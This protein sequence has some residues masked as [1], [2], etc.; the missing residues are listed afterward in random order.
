M[1]D[2]IAAARALGISLEDAAAQ[3]FRGIRFAEDGVS[4]EADFP[5]GHGYGVRRTALHELMVERAAA[6]GVRLIWDGRVSGIDGRCREVDGRQVRARW[7]VGADGGNSPTRRWAGL[8][9]CERDSRR[10]AFRRHYRVAP[11]SEFME[12]HWS[13]GCQI[14]ITPVSP[15][16]ICVVL[17]SRDPH[18]RLEDALMRFPEI[19]RRLEAGAAVQPGARRRLGFPAFAIG[20]QRPRGAGGRRLR[21]GGCHHRRGHLPA[22]PAGGAFGRGARSGRPGAVPGRAPA[23]RPASGA[24]GRTDAHARP[25]RPFAPPRV[26]RHGLPSPGF[27]RACW[28]PTSGSFRFSIPQPT[29][30]RWAGN[31]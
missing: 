9:A 6:A 20:S 21:I 26:S 8:D 22:V 17:I 3:P 1:P 23:A 28:P 31:Y 12:I 11:W 15:G 25:A 7:I 4:V 18:L 19:S 24:D 30:W 14:Y 29:D 2:G 16:E 5:R 27:S 10:F 13:D